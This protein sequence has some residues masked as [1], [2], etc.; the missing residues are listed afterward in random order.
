MVTR[1]LVKAKIDHIQEEY[2][3]VLYRI[4]QSLEPGLSQKV[5]PGR[6]LNNA[7]TERENWWR[8]VALTYGSTANAPIERADQ[9][10]FEIRE[11]FE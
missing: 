7:A 1:E 11:A 6:V 3:D 2:L 10:K 5:T 8:F 4:I 9:G